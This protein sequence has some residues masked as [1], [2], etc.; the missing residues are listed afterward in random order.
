LKLWKKKIAIGLASLAVLAC[1]AL[2]VM[3]FRLAQ[4]D[5][6]F[7]RFVSGSLEPFDDDDEIN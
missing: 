1:I 3:A 4:A 6:A 7:F 5:G 2:G